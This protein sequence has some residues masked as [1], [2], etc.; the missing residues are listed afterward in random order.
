[1]SCPPLFHEYMKLYLWS[2]ISCVYN[3]FWD[4]KS[5]LWTSYADFLLLIWSGTDLENLRVG[6]GLGLGGN[7]LLLTKL[8]KDGEK[9]CWEENSLCYLCINT[10]SHPYSNN[11]S[12]LG[13]NKQSIIDASTQLTGLGILRYRTS[14][15]RTKKPLKEI[16]FSCRKHESWQGFI[17]L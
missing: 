4:F 16:P 8:C 15:L 13:V 1:M 7:P 3:K 17:S 6:L 11:W 2:E 9:H 12:L 10:V 5:L 14:L